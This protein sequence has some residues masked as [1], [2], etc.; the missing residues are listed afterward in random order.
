MELQPSQVV[1]RTYTTEQLQEV[2]EMPTHL[3]YGEQHCDTSMLVVAGDGPALLGRDWLRKIRLD[4]AQ[5]AYNT[6]TPAPSL[7][8]LCD[9][10][11][12]VFTE[13]LGTVKQIQAT[14]R[15]K[16][17]SRPKFFRPCHVPLATR[18]ALTKKLIIWLMLVSLRKW[19]TVNGLHR[20]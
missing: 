18:K 1:L 13:E 5:I 4:W 12:E 3:L 14:L 15:V 8:A 6:S 20:L 10:Y 2:G 9:E 17:G 16:E 11:K 7:Q 19:I